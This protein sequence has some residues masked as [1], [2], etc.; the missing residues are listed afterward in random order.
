MRSM[1]PEPARVVSQ[2]P[3]HGTRPR[4]GVSGK[5]Q[6][7]SCWREMLTVH[8]QI[9]Q[10]STP[11]LIIAETDRSAQNGGYSAVSRGEGSRCPG[12]DRR[13]SSVRGRAIGE[14]GVAV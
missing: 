9:A 13:P 5:W 6:E 2:T 10:L 1:V 3:L 8:T 4:S 7:I 11:D 12:L 14:P